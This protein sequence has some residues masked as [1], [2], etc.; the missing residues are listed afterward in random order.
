MND[1]LR[2]EK[3]MSLLEILVVIAIFAIL[4]VIVT[5]SVLLSIGGSKKSESVV[6]VRENL[7]YSLAIIERQ[8]RNA[9][10]IS[11]CPNLDT[12]RIDYK[13]Q[14]DNPAFFSCVNTGGDDSYIAS[15]SA[16]LTSDTVQITRCSFSCTAASSTNPALVNVFLEAKD[17]NASGT[18][19]STVSV[20]TQIYLRDY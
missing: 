6:R 17:S 15:G 8:I 1:K 16:R 2:I 19:N 9:N 4:G 7:N 18:Q 3:G 12:L 5:R 11:E 13:D 20:N 14:D 10:S